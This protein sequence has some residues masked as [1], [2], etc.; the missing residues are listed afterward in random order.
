VADHLWSR[1]GQLVRSAQ[2]P[3]AE[4]LALVWGSR[5]DRE[6]AHGLMH[7]GITSADDGAAALLATAA[8]N[9]DQL[10]PQGQQRL[11]R[12]IVR[13]R[14]RWDNRRHGPHSAD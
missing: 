3:H 14:A 12:L 4:L 7:T 6:H 10:A 2:D 8:N 1:M 9:F 5:F 13:H 11:R